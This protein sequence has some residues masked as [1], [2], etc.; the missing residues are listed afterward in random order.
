MKPVSLK[1]TPKEAKKLDTIEYKPP[2]Y[3]YGTCLNLDGD[4]MDKLGLSIAVDPGTKFNISG[5]AEVVGIS[6]RKNASGEDYKSLDL[7][8]T[9]LAVDKQGKPEKLAGSM[10]PDM[11]SDE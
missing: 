2:E 4:M 11:K 7:Q 10:Y 1:R 8:I 5:T 6:A 9:T 3:G